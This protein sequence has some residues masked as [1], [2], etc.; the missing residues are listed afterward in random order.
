M[1]DNLRTLELSAFTGAGRGE[2]TSSGRMVDNGEPFGAEGRKWGIRRREAGAHAGAQPPPLLHATRLALSF[3]KLMEWMDAS[4]S[5][6]QVAAAHLHVVVLLVLLARTRS[7]QPLPVVGVAALLPV[8][9][10]RHDLVERPVVLLVEPRLLVHVREAHV[11]GLA[12]SGVGDSKVEPGG[13]GSLVDRLA[14]VAGGEEQVLPR[15][16]G[17]VRGLPSGG[18]V[19]AV[20]VGGEG[21]GRQGGIGGVGQFYH[22]LPGGGWNVGKDRNWRLADDHMCAVGV[23]DRAEVRLATGN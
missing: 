18:E 8:R 12:G 22:R 4:S 14:R 23:C 15:T 21:E 7:G 16:G 9:I 1:E 19:A 11:D 17:R 6:C 10:K 3:A 13:V 20:K 5:C 2:V